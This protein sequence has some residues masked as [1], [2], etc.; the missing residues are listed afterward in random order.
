MFTGEC[1]G[2]YTAVPVLLQRSRH[3]ILSIELQKTVEREAV[4]FPRQKWEG[5]ITTGNLI[6]RLLYEVL[7]LC[8][9]HKEAQHSVSEMLQGDSGN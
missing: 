7:T 3:A 8:R 9:V 4:I 2:L 1:L 6:E 5:E